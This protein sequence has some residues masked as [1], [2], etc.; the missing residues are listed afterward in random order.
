MPIELTQIGNDVIV[1]FEMAQIPNVLFATGLRL[2][3][4]INLIYPQ[5]GTEVGTYLHDNSLGIPDASGN[6]ILRS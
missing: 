5:L 3:R 4:R 2:Y 1:P 6:S